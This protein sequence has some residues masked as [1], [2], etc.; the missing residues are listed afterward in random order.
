MKFLPGAVALP[1]MAAAFQVQVDAHALTLPVE[2]QGAIQVAQATPPFVN[3]EVTEV[4]ESAGLVTLQHEDIPNL[5][6]PAMVMPFE[7]ADKKMLQGLKAG[8]RIRAQFDTVDG[9]MLL[10][11]LE[12]AR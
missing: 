10:I 9:K 12:R 5:N 3:A 6:M 7:V 2:S 4:D 1:V 11:R 8:D